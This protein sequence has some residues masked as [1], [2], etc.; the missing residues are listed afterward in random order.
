MG[1]YWS[2][3]YFVKKDPQVQGYGSTAVSIGAN[4]TLLKRPQVQGYTVVP[5]FQGSLNRWVV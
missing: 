1:F 3:H 2:K 5:Q 4:T